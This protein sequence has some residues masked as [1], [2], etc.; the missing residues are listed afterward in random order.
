MEVGLLGGVFEHSREA[1]L[2]G[3][4]LDLSF[5]F[6]GTMRGFRDRPTFVGLT[7]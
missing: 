7:I 5:N 4:V 6:K 3:G 2:L 1:G